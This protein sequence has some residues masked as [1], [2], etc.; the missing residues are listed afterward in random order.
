MYTSSTWKISSC[1]APCV[2]SSLIN[3]PPDEIR[4]GQDTFPCAGGD[5]DIHCFLRDQRFH[6]CFETFHCRL[7]SR[8]AALRSLHGGF[9]VRSPRN[10]LNLLH[11]E[12]DSFTLCH[13]RAK[14]EHLNTFK[15]IKPKRQGHN[16]VL[17]VLHVPNSRSR[18]RSSG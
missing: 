14:R 12:Y 15:D 3:I 8:W 7:L 1:F 10:C 4:R 2:V 5:P 18:A 16:L 6:F 11:V 9:R 17:T 13:Y